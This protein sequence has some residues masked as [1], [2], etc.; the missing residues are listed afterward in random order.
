LRF[1]REYGLRWQAPITWLEYRD[2]SIGFAVV[3]FARASR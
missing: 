3:D 1:V 2:D